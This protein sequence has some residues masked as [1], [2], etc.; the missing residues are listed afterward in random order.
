MYRKLTFFRYG[1]IASTNL[2]RNLGH[3]INNFFANSPNEKEQQ[4][5]STNIIFAPIPQLA[6]LAKYT[7][8]HSLYTYMI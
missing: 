7:Y 6:S 1:S 5:R 8:Q 2:Y 4:I 3:Y